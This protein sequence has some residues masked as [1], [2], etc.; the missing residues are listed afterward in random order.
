M[1]YNYS[2]LKGRIIEMFR[3]QSL[4]ATKIGLSERSLSL[5]LNNEVPFKQPEID[6]IVSVLNIDPLEISKYFFTREVQ[7]I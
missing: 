2:A 6:K 5:K 3:T 1:S 4:F 7:N